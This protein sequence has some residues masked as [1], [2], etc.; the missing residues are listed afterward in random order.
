MEK[1]T[2][3]AVPYDN[4]NLESSIKTRTR[5]KSN[6]PSCKDL[7]IS[8]KA[9]FLKKFCTVEVGISDHHLVVTIF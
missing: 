6:N 4:F 8:N 5:F 9:E 1:L 2:T 7:I 3:F